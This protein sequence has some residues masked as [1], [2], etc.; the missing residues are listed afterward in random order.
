MG[1][2][3]YTCAKRVYYS[4]LLLTSV[5]K[6]HCFLNTAIER[7]VLSKALSPGFI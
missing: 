3:Q 1:L 4:L 2:S 7:R 6:K 5:D